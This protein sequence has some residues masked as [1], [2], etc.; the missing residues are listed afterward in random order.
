MTH[1][2]NTIIKTFVERQPSIAGAILHAGRKR[3]QDT[4]ATM[5]QAGAMKASAE[6]CNTAINR[7]IELAYQHDDCGL[8][9]VD[10]HTGV[11]NRKIA[12]PWSTRNYSRYAL[13]RTEADVLAIHVNRLHAATVP[14]FTYD[15]GSKR[16]AVNLFDYPTQAA[17]VAY[18]KSA[19]LTGK[20][21]QVLMHEVR[22]RRTG[23]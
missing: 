23:D 2:N 10:A 15:A 6:L 1:R 17:A 8:C 18:W 12:M 22:S 13:Q 16:W 14:L 4:A 11:F 7:L 19:Q 21:Y 20:D 5:S 9:N 3:A